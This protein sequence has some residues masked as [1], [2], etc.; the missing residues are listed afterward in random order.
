MAAR[1][2]SS[3]TLFAYALPAAAMALPTLPV[4]VL[5]PAFYA[6]HTALSLLAV[7]T[8]LFVARLI[9]AA[10]D[11]VAGRIC[12]TPLGRLGRRRG[13]MLVGGLILA[14]GLLGLFS[15]PADAGPIWLLSFSLLLYIGWTLVQVPYLAWG[16]DLSS[17]YRERVRLT[18]H[19]EALGLVGLVLSAAWPALV[20]GLGYTQPQAFLGLAVVT[21]L[22]GAFA[23]AWMWR[24]VPEPPAVMHRFGRWRELADNLP[25]LRMMSAWL[26]NATANGTAAVMFPFFV[27]AVLGLPDA[28]RGLFLLAYFLAA[29]AAMP[30]VIVLG[31]RVSKHRL[32]CGSMLGASAVFAFVPLLGAGDQAGFVVVCV[33]TGLALG[34]DLALPPAVLADVVDWDRL[35]HRRERPA[36]FFAGS[37]FV[38][39][40]AL[41]FA[42]LI[43]PAIL[44]L[45][46]WQDEGPQ[47]SAA[48]TALTLVYA[49]LPCA[50]KLGAVALMW[51][52]PLTAE[53]HGQIRRRLDRWRPETAS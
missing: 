43:G 13:W 39:K 25:W 26:L 5:L 24:A 41:G 27:T 1:R 37:S 8:V 6:E 3:R 51:R 31:R 46:G 9:D 15:P 16:A 34:A 45:F 30:L 47:P 35:K 50:L 28:S 14:P 11:L 36:L 33:L 42:V 49:L 7:G 12:D 40:L 22:C 17:E 4:Y 52:F 48:L 29:V 2:L 10:S 53:R 38:T 44:G 20:L 21:L 18:G 19:R 32:W 23:L